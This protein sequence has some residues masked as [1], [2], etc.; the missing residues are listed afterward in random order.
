MTDMFDA[1]KR[2]EIMAKVRSSGTTPEIRVR[3]LLHSMGYR[4]RLH[5][6]D[7]PGNPDIVLPKYKT[8]IFVHG[9]FWH[10]CPTCRRAR[11]RP[12]ANADYWNAKLDRT[13]ARDRDNITALKRAGWQILVIWECETKKKNLNLLLKK[14]HSISSFACDACLAPSIEHMK[15]PCGQD[16]QVNSDLKRSL[17]SKFNH[18]KPFFCA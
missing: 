13:M 10:G 3:K 18:S 5:R 11:I 9:C 12:V 4:F 8:V 17:F 2:S 14:L 15:E 1:K 7:L 6:R 16:L